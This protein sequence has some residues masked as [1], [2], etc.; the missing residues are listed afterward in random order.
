ML[1]GGVGIYFFSAVKEQ[2]AR[3]HAGVDEWVLL[4]EGGR[5]GAGL[6]KEKCL[7]ARAGGRGS[8]AYV[9]SMRFW[10]N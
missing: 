5:H 2:T 8:Q 7:R 10:R 9:S 6:R 4:C 1:E 3:G